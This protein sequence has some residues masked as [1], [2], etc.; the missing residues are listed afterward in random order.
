M[1]LSKCC[2]VRRQQEQH[3]SS[4]LQELSMKTPYARFVEIFIVYY[5]FFK[6]APFPIFFSVVY[7]VTSACAVCWNFVTCLFCKLSRKACQ[8]SHLYVSHTQS[9][10]HQ[11]CHL[12]VRHVQVHSKCHISHL[13]VNH[14]QRYSHQVSHLYVSHVQCSKCQICCLYVSNVAVTRSLT[15]TCESCTL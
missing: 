3:L 9:N 11:I 13:Y 6:D 2:H 10:N 12:F 15:C 7:L 4:L 8:K 1:Q 14:V 5:V